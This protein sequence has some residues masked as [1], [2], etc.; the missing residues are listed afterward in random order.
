MKLKLGAINGNEEI[1]I[2]TEFSRS[3]CGFNHTATAIINGEIVRAKCHYINRTWEVYTYQT[4]LHAL[5]AKIAMLAYGCPSER[6]YYSAKKWGTAREYAH[7]L[8]NEIDN[9]YRYH[10]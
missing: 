2:A 7:S 1:D 9:R 3:R 8:S 6:S 10:Y 5:C 4:V